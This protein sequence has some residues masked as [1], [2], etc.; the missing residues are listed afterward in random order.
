MDEDDGVREQVERREDL[1]ADSL[2][3]CERLVGHFGRIEARNNTL[4]SFKVSLFASPESTL[5]IL[6]PSSHTE[7]TSSPPLSLPTV[8]L[9][10]LY[11][12]RRRRPSSKIGS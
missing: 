1:A 3:V 4:G 7:P 6:P 2:F 5:T 10:L 12:S 8:P 9:S 11:Y